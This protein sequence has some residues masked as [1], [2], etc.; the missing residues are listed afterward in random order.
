LDGK[1]PSHGSLILSDVA[2]H[3]LTLVREPCGRRGRL[4]VAHLLDKQGDAKPTNHTPSLRNRDNA[5]AFSLYDQ[6]KVSYGLC[7]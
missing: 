7:P 6:C 5:G 1:M 3:Y 2:A 4:N